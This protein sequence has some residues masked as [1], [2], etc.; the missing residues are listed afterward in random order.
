[1]GVGLWRSAGG[2][3]DGPA[4]GLGELEGKGAR[5]GREVLVWEGQGGFAL[6]AGAE[7]GQAQVETEKLL[8]HQAAAGCLQVLPGGGKVDGPVGL[9]ASIR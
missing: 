3:V 5:E 4:L 7:V 2:F 6:A 1:M 8:E 9:G